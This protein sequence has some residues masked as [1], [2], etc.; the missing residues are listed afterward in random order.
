MARLQKTDRGKNIGFYFEA[1]RLP[2]SFERITGKSFGRIPMNPLLASDTR[3]I[4]KLEK[5]YR[6]LLAAWA[7]WWAWEPPGK[8]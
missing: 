6:D 3:R 5:V 8:P 7:Q 2:A 4:P 1:E